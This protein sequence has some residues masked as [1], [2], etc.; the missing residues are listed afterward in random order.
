MALVADRP[1]LII[2][3]TNVVRRAVKLKAAKDDA[4]V[5]EVVIMAIRAYCAQEI[6]EAERIMDEERKKK[7]ERGFE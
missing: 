2:D 5:S 7:K 1:R 3:C 6:R 4:S